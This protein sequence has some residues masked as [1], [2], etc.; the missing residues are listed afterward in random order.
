[1]PYKEITKNKRNTIILIVIF[2]LFIMGLGYAMSVI[3]GDY[4][5][6]VMAFAITIIMN[7][8]AYFQ[9][10]KIILKM[11]SAKGIT[12]KQAPELYRIV[13]NL[14][15]TAGLPTPKIYLINDPAP[16]AFATGRNPE[17]ASVTVTTG[18]LKLLN[19]NELEGVIAHELSHIK[20]Y[21]VQLAM[22]VI[23]LVGITVMLSDFFFRIS[24][25]RNNRKKNGGPIMLIVAIVLAILSPIVAKIIQ[26]AISR[27]REFLADADS[28]LLTRYPEGLASALNKIS[29]QNL[30]MKKVNKVTANLY[31]ANPFAKK[32][33]LTNRLFATHPPIKERIKRLNTLNF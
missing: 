24:F 14:A 3:I 13:E 21:D 32:K 8:V 11:N 27:Q 25:F 12:K 16:N 6:I 19:K 20:N 18:L 22:M 17:H 2:S 7:L 5:Y 31:I 9:G 10:D 33:S 26:L 4:V 29:Q 15:I 23:M 28:V 1:M 30:P